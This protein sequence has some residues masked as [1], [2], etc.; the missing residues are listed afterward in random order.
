MT[1]QSEYEKV[2][3]QELRDIPKEYFPEPVRDCAYIQGKCPFEACKGEFQQGWREAKKD[4][5]ILYLNSGRESVPNEPQQQKIQIGFTPE[6][7][8]S[9]RMLAKKYRHI[10]S[11]IEPIIDQ[12]QKG[13]V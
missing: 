8:R 6:F 9:L 13:I 11:D 1:N 2:F 4:R 10:R 3:I 7:K 5:C 12:L